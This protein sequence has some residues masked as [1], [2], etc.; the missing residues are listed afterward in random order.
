MIPIL[1]VFCVLAMLLLSNYLRNGSISRKDEQAG[2]SG[3]MSLGSSGR[4]SWEPEGKAQG[5]HLLPP[6]DR[7]NSPAR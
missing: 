5:G 3:G 7:S 2:C 4:S 6:S 1:L